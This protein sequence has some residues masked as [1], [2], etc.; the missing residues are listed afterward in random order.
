VVKVDLSV[1]LTQHNVTKGNEL[2]R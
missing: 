1:H 2:E